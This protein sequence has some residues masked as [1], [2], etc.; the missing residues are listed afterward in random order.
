ML[1]A[2]INRKYSNFKLKGY[3]IKNYFRT[4]SKIQKITALIYQFAMKCYM[5]HHWMD[6]IGTEPNKVSFILYNT[7]F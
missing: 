7:R 5:L 2:L 4:C 1:I 3:S 6:S